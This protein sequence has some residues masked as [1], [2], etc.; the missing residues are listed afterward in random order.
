MPYTFTTCTMNRG[1]TLN[2][3][4]L[5]VFAGVLSSQQQIFDLLSTFQSILAKNVAPASS[6]TFYTKRCKTTNEPR[7]VS[8][9]Y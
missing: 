7:L 3:Q 6:C 8:N 9:S 4:G 5:S 1:K 2:E